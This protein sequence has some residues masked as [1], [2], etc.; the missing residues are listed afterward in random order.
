MNH[1]KYEVPYTA[2]EIIRDMQTK[3]LMSS[4]PAPG[5]RHRINL[6]GI[7]AGAIRELERRFNHGQKKFNEK[8]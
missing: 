8:M 6:V 3:G 7:V 5:H 1:D 2:D 4:V